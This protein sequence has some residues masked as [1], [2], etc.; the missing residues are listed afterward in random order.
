M[1]KWIGREEEAGKEIEGRK[2]YRGTSEKW[3]LKQNALYHLVAFFKNVLDVEVNRGDAGAD[4]WFTP[5]YL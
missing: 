3:I 4:Q 2:T 5:Y 1:K